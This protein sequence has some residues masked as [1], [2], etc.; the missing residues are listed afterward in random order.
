MSRM[1]NSVQLFGKVCS[2]PQITMG[3]DGV[4][5]ASLVMATSDRYKDAQGKTVSDMDWHF[6][7]AKGKIAEVIEK[8]VCQGTLIAIEG[9]IRTR[10]FLKDNIKMHRTVIQMRDLLVLEMIG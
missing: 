8:K 9:R 7:I 2:I 10:Q 4:K 6:A 1:E 5:N 3:K